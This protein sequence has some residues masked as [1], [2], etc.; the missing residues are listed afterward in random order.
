[1]F[2][3]T[4]CDCCGRRFFGKGRPLRRFDN[5][6]IDVC[7]AACVA[8]EQKRRDVDYASF[9]AKHQAAHTA[10]ADGVRRSIA[11]DGGKWHV[12]TIR[13]STPEAMSVARVGGAPPGIRA[14]D[15][16]VHQGQHAL[17]IC[18]LP[19]APLGIEADGLSVFMHVEPDAHGGVSPVGTLGVVVPTSTA[20]TASEVPPGAPLQQ[21]RPSVLS[22]ADPSPM[23][24]PT[25][26]EEAA[27][28]FIGTVPIS[29][30]GEAMD[31]RWP[32]GADGDPKTLG[33]F[34]AQLAGSDLPW[35]DD[36]ETFREIAGVYVFERG[37]ILDLYG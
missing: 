6:P 20:R 9:R 36:A 8:A 27:L 34:L 18:T 25:S 24:D 21:L 31:Q 30:E 33:R 10:W 7:S 4:T 37:A 32:G 35:E 22:V 19:G 17:H 13:D 3:R 16:P 5:T 23:W 2:S 28:S 1:V 15:W 26:R 12:L 29:F 14:S 11:T